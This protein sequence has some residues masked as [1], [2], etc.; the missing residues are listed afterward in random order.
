MINK[1]KIFRVL[2]GT[3]SLGWA[4]TQT[5]T[6]RMLNYALEGVVLYAAPVCCSSQ[7]VRVGRELRKCLVLLL[8]FPSCILMILKQSPLLTDEIKSG[9]F[10]S[11]VEGN[12]DSLLQ[13]MVSGFLCCFHR[14]VVEALIFSR[15]KILSLQKW[16]DFQQM[17][18]WLKLSKWQTSSEVLLDT[19]VLAFCPVSHLLP[20]LPGWSGGG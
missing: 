2:L 14:T 8:H 9:F 19:A 17:I 16:D 11:E 7:N 10:G 13:T 15:I 12:T 6:H 5:H 20:L 18:L 1:N 3:N 4:P